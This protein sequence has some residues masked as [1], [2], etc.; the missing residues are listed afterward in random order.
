MQ[1][2]K[3]WD[4][5]VRIFHWSLVLG[6]AANATLVSDHS[7]LHLWIGYG[8]TGLVLFRIL[9]GFIGT[10]YARFSSFPPSLSAAAGQLSDMVSGNKR[11]H[12]GHTPLGAWMIYNLLGSLL[13]IGLTGYMLT[14]TVLAN[15][16][17][18]EDLHEICVGWAELSVVLHILAVILES[19]RTKVNLPRAMITGRKEIA[20]E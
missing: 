7:P 2:V 5:V 9:W 16:N 11:S 14:T 13:M 10:Y 15:A 17:W 12:R 4:P 1:S 20:V 3:V 19:R 6:F 8:I 18:V